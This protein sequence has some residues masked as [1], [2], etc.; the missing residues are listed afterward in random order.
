MLH[1]G[2]TNSN[3]FFF[4]IVLAKL[5]HSE[6]SVIDD[7]VSLDKHSYENLSILQV[8]NRVRNTKSVVNLEMKYINHKSALEYELRLHGKKGDFPYELNGSREEIMLAY[9]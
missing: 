6:N 3:T 1:N 9:F 2:Y 5:I 8:P 7:I 4:I